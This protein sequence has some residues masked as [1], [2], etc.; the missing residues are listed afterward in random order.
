MNTQAKIKR[1]HCLAASLALLTFQPWANRASAQT[2]TVLNFNVD[3]NGNTINANPAVDATSYLN[4]Y[5]ITVTELTPGASVYI[6]SD[7]PAPFIIASP[8]PNYFSE[9]GFANGET[10]TLLTF[11]EPLTSLSLTRCALIGPPDNTFGAWSFEVYSGATEISPASGP[12]SG[13]PYGGS[14]Q[15]ATTTT[16]TGTDITSLE[17]DGNL[18]G[19]YGGAGN[20]LDNITMTTAAVPEPSTLALCAIGLSLVSYAAQRRTVKA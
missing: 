5:G 20:D 9:S 2:T 19:H 11:A 7:V 3:A 10:S 8:G 15:P 14:S 13:G 18:E 1:I 12:A 16:F 17:I 4:S 6:H